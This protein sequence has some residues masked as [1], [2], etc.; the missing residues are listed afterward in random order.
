VEV[1]SISATQVISSAPAEMVFAVTGVGA[2]PADPTGVSLVPIN[3]STAIIQWDLATDLDVLIGGEVLIRHDPRSLPTAEW[4]TSNAIVQ[5]AAGNQTQ[6]QVPLLAGTYFIAFRD[7]SGVRSVN[8]VAIPAVLPTPQPR[9]VLKTWAENPSFTGQGDNLNLN[10]PPMLLLLEDGYALLDEEGDPLLQ[11]SLNGYSGL[12]LNPS[13]GLTGHY[14]YD[15]ELDL[16][17]IYD[18]NIRRRVVSFPTAVAGI[19]FDEVSGL[20]DAQPGDFDGTDLDVVNAVTYVRTTDDSLSDNFLLE[21]DDNLLL[22]DSTFLFMDPTWSDWNEYV[23]AIVRGRGIQLKVEGSTRSQLVGLVVSELGATAEL[24]QRVESGGPL[25]TLDT[26]PLTVT[27]ADPFYTAPTV[28]VTT[29]D[30]HS[31]DELEITNITRTSFDIGVKHGA[32]YVIHDFGYSATGY[33]K[34]V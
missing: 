33:G 26:G 15:E 12:F 3:E 2:P 18:V 10:L 17:Q 22:E 4:S 34:E 31:N 1:Y 24:Q 11:E 6:K 32:S 5:A 20:F 23:N 25:T 19:T 30:M 21:D 7:Q 8:P 13:V 29:Y 27:F 16:T 9:L 14:V 28:N